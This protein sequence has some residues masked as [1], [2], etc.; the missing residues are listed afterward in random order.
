MVPVWIMLCYGL[1]AVLVHL[2]HRLYIRRPAGV[3]RR[4][5]YI[6]VTRN[7]GQ[8]ME[9][10]LRAISWY[11]RL[12]GRD[13]RITVYDEDSDDD[14]LAIT[15]RMKKSG[16]VELSVYGLTGSLEEA[17]LWRQAGPADEEKALFI[18]LRLPMEAAKIPYVHI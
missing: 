14:T 15:H 10:Y 6:L 7:H 5:H 12:R 8:Q 9:W 3:P 17:E 2:M 4:E 13:C 1:A 18:D 11:A 16:D